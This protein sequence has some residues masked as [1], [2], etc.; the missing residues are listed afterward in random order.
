MFLPYS[1]DEIGK[2]D[3]PAEIYF[4][5]NKTGQK[6]VYYVGHSEASTAG[7]VTTTVSVTVYYLRLKSMSRWPKKWP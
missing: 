7:N 4:I 2:Y 5:M 1:F 6:D 3:V